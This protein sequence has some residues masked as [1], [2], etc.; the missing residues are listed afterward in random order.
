MRDVIWR[1]VAILVPALVI[2][3]KLP[4]AVA[5]RGVRPDFA[6]MGV[7]VVTLRFGGNVGVWAGFVSGL[8][9]D[10]S[11]PEYLGA[12]ALSLSITAWLLGR[13]AEHVDSTSLPVQVILLAAAGLTDAIVVTTARHLTR[14]LVGLA[15]FFVARVPDVL[16]TLVAAAVIFALVGRHLIPRRVRWGAR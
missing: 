8:F 10:V 9:L 16:Y 6:L 5:I 7:F 4:D 15:E 1:V 11:T 12:R 14:P 13:A 2:H 3:D